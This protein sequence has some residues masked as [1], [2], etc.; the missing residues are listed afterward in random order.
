MAVNFL[1]KLF[2]YDPDKRM[3]ARE[4]LSH[5][6]FQEDPQPTYKSVWF[7]FCCFMEIETRPTSVFQQQLSNPSQLPPQ[8]RITLDEAPSMMPAQATHAQQLPAQFTQQQH[9]QG[10]TQGSAASFAS[11]SGG[12]AGH[13]KKRRIG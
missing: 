11:L 6:W 10:Q 4:A 1:S 8:R 5:S 9:L 13:T 3:T 12:H 2:I 7:S